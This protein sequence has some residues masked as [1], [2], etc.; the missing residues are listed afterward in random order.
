[1]DIAQRTWIIERRWRIFLVLSA[2]V[3]PGELDGDGV[4]GNRGRGPELLDLHGHRNRRRVGEDALDEPRG[5]GLQ[6][7][8]RGARSLVDDEGGELVVI[9]DPR[10]AVRAREDR[11][12]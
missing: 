7:L 6:E 9:E 1:M 10:Q 11:E 12:R 2:V 8:V 4:D 3:V 5:E